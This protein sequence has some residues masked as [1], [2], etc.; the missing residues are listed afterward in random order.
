MHCDDRNQSIKVTS[1][2]SE[3]SASALV[4]AS[5][6]LRNMADYMRSLDTSNMTMSELEERAGFVHVLFY[7][8][9]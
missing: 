3:L 7:I 4:D 9:P 8:I 2:A 6:A 1:E 5:L